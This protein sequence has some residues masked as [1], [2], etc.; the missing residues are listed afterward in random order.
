[1]I[2]SKAKANGLGGLMPSVT[3][4]GLDG[5][6]WPRQPLIA[7]R[8]Y[9]CGLKWP[10]S[11]RKIFHFVADCWCQNSHYKGLTVEQ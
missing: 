11:H 2:A 6:L 9:L 8:N 5:L 4:D 10:R 7:D 1:M 3:S